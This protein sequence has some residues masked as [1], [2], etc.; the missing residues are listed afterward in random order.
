MAA[1]ALNG[2]NPDLARRCVR[3]AIM[4]YA[5][6]CIGSARRRSLTYA[7]SP[8]QMVISRLYERLDPFEPERGALKRL[9]VN[10]R[11]NLSRALC[12][13]REKGT[14]ARDESGDEKTCTTGN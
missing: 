10:T 5:H 1:A 4:H 6:M 8:S 14:H 3:P 7:D 13:P 12:R 9:N 11:S 2:F